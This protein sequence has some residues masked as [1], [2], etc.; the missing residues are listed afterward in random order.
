MAL[1]KKAID[2]FQF[3]VNG[4]SQQIHW[5]GD[6]P[7]FG[8]RVFKSGKK[9]FVLSYRTTTGRS[10][11]MT[12]GRYGVLTLSQAR[13]KA[14]Q[15]L[16]DVV[17]GGDPADTRQKERRA[18][19]VRDFA[20]V[21]IDQH[22][23]PRKKSWKEDE[24]RLTKYV[25]PALGARKLSDVT[26]AD[27]SRLHK[28]MGQRTAYEA[29][30]V[31]ALIAVLYTKAEEWGYVV[32]GHPN[33]AKRVTPFRERS[34][35]RYV[36]PAEFPAIAAAIEDEPNLYVRAA[37]KLYFLTGLRRAELLSLR[38]SDVDLDEAVL[39]LAET[40]AGNSHSVP[41]S[42]PARSILADLPR[43][44]GNPFVLPAEAEGRHLVNVGKPW[45]RVRARAWLKMNPSIEKTLRQQAERD[46]KLRKRHGKHTSDRPAAVEARLVQ[47]AEAEVSGP[48]AIRLHDLRR[49]VGSW[50]AMSGASLPLIGKVLNHSN[51]STT[52]VYARL[53]EDGPR[54][55]LDGL[56]EKMVQAGL[57]T[58]E[59]GHR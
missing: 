21:Y 7:G 29:N 32:D 58:E 56:G 36:K 28:S 57:K 22:A 45:R 53:A 13:D 42:A 1:T 44:A 38:W 59:L 33:P 9:S 35:D 40:K 55:A 19:S 11:L 26:R 43:L 20:K 49:T 41:L 30:R 6:L 46:V 8:V 14:I 54:A 2:R 48:D 15:T 37:L 39:R 3:D 27:T 52:Q 25:L 31:L 5:D 16:S 50:L 47:L 51:A 23:K 18:I 4:T 24:R 12:L 34:R 10:R 17:D